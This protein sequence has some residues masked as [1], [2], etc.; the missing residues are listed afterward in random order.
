MTRRLLAVGSS[1]TRHSPTAPPPV[2]EKAKSSGGLPGFIAERSICVV[3][4][5]AGV[6]GDIKAPPI[7]SARTTVGTNARWVGCNE[8]AIG[9]LPYRITRRLSDR[10]RQ[11]EDDTRGRASGEGLDRPGLEAENRD[12]C[13]QRQSQRPE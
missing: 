12:Y 13:G 8:N 6:F 1:I 2:R 7:A 10:S 3:A 5:C 11:M 4:L 9:A